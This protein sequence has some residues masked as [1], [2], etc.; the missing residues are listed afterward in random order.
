MYAAEL[1]GDVTTYK[2]NKPSFA[3]YANKISYRGLERADII[4]TR[5]DKIDSIDVEFEIISKS[6]NY[7]LIKKKNDN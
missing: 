6:G 5:M 2:L 3:F 7:L 4:L 1:G